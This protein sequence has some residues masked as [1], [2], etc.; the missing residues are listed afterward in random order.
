[1]FLVENLPRARQDADDGDISTT[2]SLKTNIAKELRRQLQQPWLPARC[3]GNNVVWDGNRK[4][5]SYHYVGGFRQFSAQNLKKSG[6]CLGLQCAP[7]QLLSSLLQLSTK[8]NQELDVSNMSFTQSQNSSPSKLKSD[9]YQLIRAAGSEAQ[10]AAE[11]GDLSTK[12][13]TLQVRPPAESNREHSIFKMT[14][15]VLHGSKEVEEAET[16]VQEE[17]EEDLIRCVAITD[18]KST[19]LISNIPMLINLII[20]YSE[21]VRSELSVYSL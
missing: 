15:N 1:M 10:I 4:T 18:Y 20:I 16:P 11:S 13:E 3:H 12:M 6:K 14:E 2:T 9:V 8:L 21:L 19:F 7:D 17:D 5:G